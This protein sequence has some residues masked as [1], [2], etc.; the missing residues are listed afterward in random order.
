MGIPQKTI[1]SLA[2]TGLL[3]MTVLFAPTGASAA[4]FSAEASARATIGALIT[5]GD[6]VTVTEVQI[7][8]DE[9]FGVTSSIDGSGVISGEAV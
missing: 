6:S 8:G 3:A 1:R 7:A 2:A 5:G 9:R 4:T